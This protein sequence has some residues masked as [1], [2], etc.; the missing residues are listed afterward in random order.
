MGGVGGKKAVEL[1]LDTY[2]E[3]RLGEYAIVFAWSTNELVSRKT[4]LSVY[5]RHV[6]C[7]N[8]CTFLF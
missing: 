3:M 2:Q 7:K 5:K 6:L 1:N 4:I 8:L